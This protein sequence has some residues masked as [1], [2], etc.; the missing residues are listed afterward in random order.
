MF[1]P[2]LSRDAFRSAVFER[3]GHLCVFCAQPAA[4]AHHILERRLWPDGGYYRDNGASVCPSHHMDCEKTVITVEKVREACKIKS[5]L[6]PPHLYPDQS[7]DKWGNPVLANG[8][9]LRGELFTDA[10]VQKILAAGGV[11][12]LFTDRVKYPR[13]WHLPW[14]PGATKDDRIL[15]SVA[16]FEGQRVIVTEKMDGEN[17]SV[18][19]DG[20]C[21]ARSLDSAS[22][23][24]Q[25][26]A[27]AL[28]GRVG[29]ELPEMWRLCGENVFAVH[30]I[31]YQDLP[32]YFMGFSLWNQANDCL[33]WD[34]TLEWFDLL[35]V[36]AVPVLF[37]GLFD[38]R[39]IRALYDEKRD[40]DVREGYVVRLASSFSYA[41]FPTS[42]AKLV[43]SNHV[44]SAQHWR[45][46][47]RIEQ[48]A[49]AVR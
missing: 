22:H 14:S 47:R 3:D 10:S 20:G 39:R 9:R 32:G 23:P 46:G 15:T 16:H 42:V 1:A 11:L 45:A 21:H 26:W 43:R 37:D 28:A 40:R 13:T 33:A 34:E 7:Y 29:P 35:G 17:T 36:P 27:R 25:G 8:Q 19:S 48:N 49:C 30:S 41:K 24:S 4:D 44:T 5:I 18:Y 2:L 12:D 6:V 31:R 38:E